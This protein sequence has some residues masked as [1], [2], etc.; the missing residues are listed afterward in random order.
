MKGLD[1]ENMNQ[2]EFDK[3]IDE[4]VAPNN[5]IPYVIQKMVKS[6]ELLTGFKKINTFSLRLYASFGQANNIKYGNIL[7]AYFQ[8]TLEDMGWELLPRDY[9]LKEEEIK[10]YNNDSDKVN[11]DIVAKK[12]EKLIFIEQKIL[13]NHDSTKKIGQLRNFQEKASVIYRNYQCLD[14]YGFEWF[15]DDSQRK[16]GANWIVHNKTYIEDNPYYSEKLYVLYGKELEQKLT[17]LTGIN[18][19]GLLE[20]FDQQMKNWHLSHGKDLPELVFDKLPMDVLDE[21]KKYS[22]ASVY[23]MFTNKDLIEQIFPIVFPNNQVYKAYYAYLTSLNSDSLNKRKKT[24]Y[25][26][27]LKYLKEMIN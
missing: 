6:P 27:L 12:N 21:L 14:I 22:F 23:K 10:F 20:K 11:V 16:N 5:M 18:H 8:K 17:T 19:N 24:S 13:D 7:E 9:A 2:I 4:V 3:L 15:I 26:N 25:D 1:L